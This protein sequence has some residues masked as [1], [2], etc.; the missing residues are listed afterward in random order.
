MEIYRKTIGKQ[1]SLIL[2]TDS[3]IYKFMKSSDSVAT[4]ASPQPNGE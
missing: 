2:S 4:P 3:D 1:S